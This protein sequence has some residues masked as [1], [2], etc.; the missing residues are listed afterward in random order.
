M[1]TTAS[2]RQ[3]AASL[4]ELPVWTVEGLSDPRGRPWRVA[5]TD[6]AP[7]V[8]LM[9]KLLFALLVIHDFPQK[10]G[11]PF[12]P[13]IPALDALRTD[14]GTFGILVSAAFWSA[15][16]FLLMN[17][18]VRRASMVLG[19]VLLL[20]LISSKPVFRNHLFICGCYF[21]L[22]GLHR[23]GE[24]PW[25]L[26]AQMSVIY[27]GAFLNKALDPAWHSGAFMHNW[28]LT[29]RENPFY[30]AIYPLLPGLTLA[31]F[32]SW[33]A[34][35]SEALMAVLFA[36]PR[37]R[38]LAVWMG[39]LFHGSLFVL[40]RGENFGHFLEDILIVYVAFLAWPRG[41]I[42]VAL[43]G[44]IGGWWRRLLAMLDWDGRID[45]RPQTGPAAG[46]AELRTN[47]GRLFRGAGALRAAV[48]YSAGFYVVLF[49]GYHAALRLI[50]PPWGFVV[51]VLV[52]GMITAFLVPW[53]RILPVGVR[54]RVHRGVS[55]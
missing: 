46:H 2:V 26:F 10:I 22:A 49:A 30:E 17:V 40:L 15:G 50:T 42:D 54:R 39:V 7:Q 45:F 23:R 38:S 20:V 41:R 13:F 14:S 1:S 37:T 11:D 33:T 48:R 21:L 25:L 52:G 5:G 36:L 4:P 43:S 9:G 31:R 35:L 51:V 55:E 27:F 19:G 47:D 28:L 29:A 16:V 32:L 12:I 44:R 6:M 18:G 34:F 53:S 8:L 3:R 24:T